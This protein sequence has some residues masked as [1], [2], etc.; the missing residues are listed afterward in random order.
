MATLR[1]IK[2]KISGIN[3]TSNHHK[4]NEDGFSGKAEKSPG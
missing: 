1:D 4:D 3:S 2:R